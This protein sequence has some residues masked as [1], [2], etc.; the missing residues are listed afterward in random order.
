M[1][2]YEVKVKPY[3]CNEIKFKWSH[4]SVWVLFRFFYMLSRITPDGVIRDSMSSVLSFALI[5]LH[6]VNAVSGSAIY[7]FAIFT[8]AAVPS[9]TPGFFE[10]IAS[11][12]L[13]GDVAFDLFD[14]FESHFGTISASLDFL[15]QLSIFCCLDWFRNDFRLICTLQLLIWF[16]A[17]L[18]FTIF[19]LTFCHFALFNYLIYFPVNF[20]FTN[21][22]FTFW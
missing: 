20:H 15:F 14:N 19:Q 21:F 6:L 7:S 1:Y 18:H 17:N 12:E 9:P 2:C 16:S 13:F 8:Y 22:W 11:L 3:H 5:A 10:R 4:A